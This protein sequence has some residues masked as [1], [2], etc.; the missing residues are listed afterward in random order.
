MLF[1]LALLPLLLCIILMAVFNIPAKFSLPISWLVACV[2]GLIFWKMEFLEVLAYSL[3]GIFNSLDV[4]ITV[5]GAV[6]IMNTLKASGAMN[7][8]N[9]GFKSISSDSRVQLI[10]IGWMF[11]GFLEGAAGFGSPAALAG[12]LLVSLGF[13]PV[14][15]VVGALIMDTTSVSF[16]AVGTPV[17]QALASLGASVATDGFTQGITIWTAIPHAIVG[18]FIP[19]IAVAV[20]MKFFTKEKS[21][22][23]ALS[24]LP[25]AAYAGILFTLPYTIIA[26]TLGYEFPSLLGALIGLPILILTT[27][28]GFLIPKKKW[29]F[30]GE[31]TWDE[32]WKSTSPLPQNNESK[33][34]IL[35][36]WTP[37]LLIAFLLIITRLPFLPFKSILSGTGVAGNFFAPKISNLFNVPNTS[38]TFKWAWLPGFIFILIGVATIFIHKMKKPEVKIAYKNTLKQVGGAVITIMFGLALVQIM[39]YSGSNDIASAE[40]KSMIFY[41]ADGLSKVGRELFVGFSP[42]I[43]I[44]GTFISGSNTVSNTLFTNLQYQSALNLALPPT[45][46]V[47]MQIVGGAVGNMVSINSTVTACA[48]VGVSGKEGKIIRTNIIPASIYA[49]LIIVVFAVSIFVFNFS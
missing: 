5:I 39:R 38:Y 37:Y 33:M 27:R 36:A 30:S 7:S 1:V 18:T 11:G 6:L 47:S 12:P 46:I 9:N 19:F 14:A 34:S 25:F 45:L 16:G 24:I 44:L 41:L 2:I 49:A 26:V 42:F 3:S 23:S 48:T 29:N 35:K 17:S 21:F 22:K 43:G 32:S 15:A 40:T 13:P 20:I 28:K 10:I 31:E 8:I 4:L